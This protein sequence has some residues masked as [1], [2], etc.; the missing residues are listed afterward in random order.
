MTLYHMKIIFTLDVSDPRLNEITESI[1]GSH[2]VLPS[3]GYRQEG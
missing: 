3:A 2:P 1:D